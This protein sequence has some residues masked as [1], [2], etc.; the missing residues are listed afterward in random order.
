MHL[1]ANARGCVLDLHQRDVGA[2][3]QDSP[4][5]RALARRGAAI[6]ARLLTNGSDRTAAA[7]NWDG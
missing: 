4:L 7:P 2:V 3:D 5:E 6:E 1:L